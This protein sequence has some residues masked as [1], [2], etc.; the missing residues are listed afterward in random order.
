MKVKLENGLRANKYP[1]LLFETLIQIFGGNG[2][3]HTAGILPLDCSLLLESLEKEK[4][5]FTVFMDFK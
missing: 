2:L 1:V 5:K 4:N 3:L